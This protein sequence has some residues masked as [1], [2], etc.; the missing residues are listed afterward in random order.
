MMKLAH[1][2]TADDVLAVVP[3]GLEDPQRLLLYVVSVEVLR[4]RA[5]VDV[6]EAALLLLTLVEK[7]GDI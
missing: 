2:E 7:V 6:A 1:I 5:V 3:E 4:D